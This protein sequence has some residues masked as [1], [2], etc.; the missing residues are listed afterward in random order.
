MRS[1]ER[2]Q[3]VAELYN[4]MQRAETKKIVKEAVDKAVE[5][6]VPLDELEAEF[7]RWLAQKEAPKSGKPEKETPSISTNKENRIIEITNDI[8]VLDTDIRNIEKET[9]YLYNK[10]RVTPE[11]Y[12]EQRETLI[13][14]YR[15]LMKS[16]TEKQDKLDAL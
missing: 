5:A 15:A 4:R 10:V 13:N 2:E 3:R 11:K 14:K 12:R 7:N 16:K 8:D 6:G 1:A 9:R